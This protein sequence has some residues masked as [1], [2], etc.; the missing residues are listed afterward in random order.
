[1]M[2]TVQFFARARDLV[3]TSSATLT[4]PDGSTVGDLRRAL[5][6]TYPSMAAL[7]QHSAF[8]VDNEYAGDDV[9][10]FSQA[11]VALLPPVSGG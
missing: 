1:M 7:L 5:T 11:E 6:Q 8:A 4:L 3:G 9:P 10:L 2:V